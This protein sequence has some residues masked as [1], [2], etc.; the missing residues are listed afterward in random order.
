MPPTPGYRSRPDRR[1]R[2]I[3][4]AVVAGTLVGCQHTVRVGADRTVSIALT[5]YRLAPDK[6][7]ASAGLLTFEVH[8]YGRLTHN[9]AV[10]QNASTDGETT[11]IPPG[12]T[13]ELSL[14]LPA[15]KYSMVST[16]FED[17]SLGLNGTLTVTR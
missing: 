8:N 9:L 11:P 15:G 10:T 12:S 13:A 2:A 4:L 17:Q 1:A 3:A 7:R 5:E 16:M 14:Y 6:L